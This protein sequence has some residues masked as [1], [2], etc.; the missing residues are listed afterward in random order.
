MR[1]MSHLAVILS[2]SLTFA[3]LWT[4]HVALGKHRGVQHSGP[5]T[6]PVQQQ[7]TIEGL[8]HGL[9]EPVELPFID[10]RLFGP[11]GIRMWCNSLL[12]EIEGPDGIQA[13]GES[14][15]R[16]GDDAAAA[17]WFMQKLEEKD[18]FGNAHYYG[19][20]SAR[21]IHRG[22]V[23]AKSLSQALVGYPNRDATLVSFL[24][25]YWAFI[26]YALRELDLPSYNPYLECHR[27][28]NQN[29]FT[30]RHEQFSGRYTKYMIDELNAA[31]KIMTIQDKR[32]SSGHSPSSGLPGFMPTRPT[33]VVPRGSVT[34]FNTLL[35]ETLRYFIQ[36]LQERT[37]AVEYACPLIAASNLYKSI[38]SGTSSFEGSFQRASQI[39][40]SL[41]PLAICFQNGGQQGQGDWHSPS[42]LHNPN[43][44][45]GIPQLVR[46]HQEAP[47]TIS[48]FS[49]YNPGMPGFGQT[50]AVDLSLG[51]FEIP[52]NR[53]Q[54]IQVGGRTVNAI[55]FFAEGIRRPS[56]VTIW[57]NGNKQQGY[58][59]VPPVD[60]HFVTFFRDRYNIQTI[61]MLNHGPGKL[62]VHQVV[63]SISN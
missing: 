37:T 36:D 45:G 28:S 52:D 47:A 10:Q 48:P 22:K 31:L 15:Y 5:K 2:V 40:Q 39:V 24:V 26:S 60:P 61:E 8:D 50:G 16:A 14:L 32:G 29:P 1:E 19:P 18:R 25:D 7:S 49:L 46:Q 54:I 41:S 59:W 13:V 12:A 57:I 53:M 11:G 17:N 4:P 35:R 21:A 38:A 55:H 3:A 62:L 43:N 23:L 56:N 51:R 44:G 9:L 30:V 42:P 63:L 58:H 20:F 34:A 6:V 33:I 27:C